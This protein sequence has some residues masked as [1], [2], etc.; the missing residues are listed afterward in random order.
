VV[1]SCGGVVMWRCGC[2]LF[3]WCCGVMVRWCDGVVVLWC[4]GVKVMHVVVMGQFCE[5]NGDNAGSMNPPCPLCLRSS[6]LKIML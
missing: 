3:W 5:K 2:V 1:R 4:G 6:A